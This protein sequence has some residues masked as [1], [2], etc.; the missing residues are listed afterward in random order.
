MWGVR[1]LAKAHIQKQQQLHRLVVTPKH[2]TVCGTPPQAGVS[3][4]IK[5]AAAIQHS[6]KAQTTATDHTHTHT[7]D[8]AEN[9]LSV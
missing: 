7:P 1:T 5:H 8:Y 6:T 9:L 3:M 4:P 2:T